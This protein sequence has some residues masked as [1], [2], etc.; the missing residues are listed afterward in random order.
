MIKVGSKV[1]NFKVGD[2]VTRVG[3]PPTADG[4]IAAHWGGYAELGIAK[5]HWAMCK[6]GV[7]KEEWNSYRVNQI[8]PTGIEPA[9]ATMIITWRETLS[10][11]KR[12]GIGRGCSV[13]ILGSGGNGLAF[14]NHALNL[15]AAN[16]V[17]TGNDLRRTVA[18]AIG[19]TDYYNYRDDRLV[20]RLIYDYPDGFDF[21]I[22]A[23]GKAGEI[24]KM[25]PLIKDGGTIGIYGID[26]YD[27][28]TITPNK[29]GKTFKFYGG[30][31]DEE[32]T[33]EQVISYIRKGKLKAHYWLNL[34]A[35][36]TLDSINEA[37]EAIQQKKII[38]ALIKLS[39]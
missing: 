13:L 19:V 33:H 23:V 20:D 37:F 17:M 6:D 18:Q 26:D 5:D 25:L 38:K 32:E 9:E 7:P 28:I 8:I 24:N 30:A 27:K 10:Y 4:K 34:D 21:I 31:Y 14:A 29:A 39:E 11:M 22:D 2:L 1:R 12:M 36:F 15:G 16:V 35:P 3:A